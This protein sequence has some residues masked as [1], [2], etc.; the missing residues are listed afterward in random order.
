VGFAL[1]VVERARGGSSADAD[2]EHV[3]FP[4]VRSDIA[5]AQ[6]REPID[7]PTRGSSGERRHDVCRVGLCG[8]EQYQPQNTRCN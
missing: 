8:L 6:R 3:R 5:E 4:L 1:C 7:G 2:A